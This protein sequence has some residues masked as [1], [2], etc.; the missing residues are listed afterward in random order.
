MSI[1]RKEATRDRYGK[2]LV[3]LAQKDRNVVAMD[4]DLGRSTR[5]FR[6][7]E[8]DPE[9]F[10]EMGIAE[11]DMISTAAGLANMGKIV[12]VNS[13]AV[14]ITGR[15]FDQIRQQVALPRSNV[16]ICGSSAGL[17][18]GPDGATHQSV[19][20]VAL[21]RVLPYMT[22][23]VP[24]DGNQ[25]EKA[26][27]AAYAYQG[28]VYL[29]LSRYETENFISGDANFQIGQADVLK[30]GK[31]FVLASCGPVLRN[32]IVA[33][34]IL[35]QKGILAGI[36]NFHTIKPFDRETV[37]RL[38]REYQSIVSV[39]EH[40]IYGGLGSAIAECLAEDGRT[41][42]KASLVRLG[43]QDMFGESGTADE[44]LQ[45]HGLDPEGIANAV[46][47]ITAQRGDDT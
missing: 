37:K 20:D 28:P 21:M 35:A 42:A 11:Q 12:F 45:K 2:V 31:N 10:I 9:R 39:E 29:R 14:F 5:S 26:V 46:I 36:V 4:C 38:A 27:L 30:D 41:G 17:T 16:K 40:S 34:E 18:E 1:Q 19:L 8:A 32:V 25:T 44:V 22:V 7:T 3:E 15:A 13:F 24:A 47:K 23:I 6:I 33:S 43:V